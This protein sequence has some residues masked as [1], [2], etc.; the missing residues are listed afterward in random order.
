MQP[1]SLQFNTETV[2]HVESTEQ[3]S[4]QPNE[5]NEEKTGPEAGLLT[6]KANRDRDASANSRCCTLLPTGQN[7]QVFQ[8][9]VGLGADRFRLNALQDMTTLWM[10]LPTIR[11]GSVT[12]LA[13]FSLLL[14]GKV[15]SVLLGSRLRSRV[16]LGAAA[17]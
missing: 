5:A 16:D 9:Q 8:L 12:F 4:N 10:R 2:F 13:G 3:F 6:P 17:P 15:E 1:N 11:S 14:L 7:H